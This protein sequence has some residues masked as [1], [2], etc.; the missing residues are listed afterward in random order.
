MPR[1]VEVEAVDLLWILVEGQQRGR[2]VTSDRRRS[3]CDRRRG[4]DCC[5]GGSNQF[6]T[7]SSAGWCPYPA[8]PA[9]GSRPAAHTKIGAG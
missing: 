6:K 2:D 5:V 9:P 4:Q 3:P 8:V 7:A 1:K